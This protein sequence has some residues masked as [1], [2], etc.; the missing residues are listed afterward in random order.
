MQ[1]IVF[2]DGVCNLCNNSVDFIIRR[3]K[4]AT[5][6]F[7]PLQTEP[8]S[9]L[10]SS[11]FFDTGDMTT[12]V[13]LQE[14]KLY[15]KSRAALEICRRLDGL[16]P[17]LYV[18]RLVPAFLRDVIYNWVSRNRYGWFGR[19]DSCRLPQPNEKRRFLSDEPLNTTP[20]S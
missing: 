8:A 5:F 12:L 10:L 7:A 16:W 1:P 20:V 2:F 18:F 17:I 11:F 14:G 3:D 15:T 13:L 19:R 6:L 4:K 9:K